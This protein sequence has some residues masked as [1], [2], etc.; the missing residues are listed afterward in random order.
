MLPQAYQSTF[1][2]SGYPTNPNIV[3][4]SVRRHHL[5]SGPK[6]LKLIKFDISTNP[7]LQHINGNTDHALALA[8]YICTLGWISK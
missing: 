5:L 3:I 8:C 2:V 7:D 1:L 4:T 6:W